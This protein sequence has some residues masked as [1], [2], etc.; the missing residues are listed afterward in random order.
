MKK[1][2]INYF[3]KLLSTSFLL[4]NLSVHSFSQKG[5]WILT[6]HQQDGNTLVVDSF[7][8]S[9]N[10]TIA[11]TKSVLDYK[12]SLNLQ[13]KEDFY[14][15][16]ATITSSKAVMPAYLSISKK[17]NNGEVPYNFDGIVRQ[18]NIYRQSPHEPNDY[19]FKGLSK[20][21]IP[22]LAI[23]D[24]M[25][26][27]VA[28]S[29]SPVFYDNYTTQT[30]DLQKKVIA[31]SAGDNGNIFQDNSFKPKIDTAT[32]KQKGQFRIEPHYFDIKE[33]DTHPFEGIIGRFNHLDPTK[34]RRAVNL[35]VSKNWSNGKVTDLFGSSFFSTAYMNLR[36]NETGKS[37]YWVV[38][39]I[40]YANK[41]YTRDAFW[42]SMILP[43]SFAA[44]CYE[45]E[46]FNDKI[47]TGA[48]RPL[49]TIIWA[50]KTLQ[51]GGKVDTAR[52]RRI[53]DITES[54][55]KN[56]YY[57]GYVKGTAGG[58]WQGWADNLAFEKEDA[59]SNNQGLFVVALM[60]AEQM[61]IHPKTPISL[62]L[63][64]YQHLFNAKINSFPISKQKDTVLSVDALM[65][66]LLSQVILG[67]TLVS[68]QDALAHYE[69]MKA[70]AMC[71]N[72][73]KDFC[74]ADGSYL[75]LEQYR[76]KSFESAI[77]KVID[78]EYQMGGSWYLYDM[79]MLMDAHIH[80]AKDAEDLMIWRTKLEFAKGNTTHEFINTVSGKPFKPNMGWNAGVY[81]IWFELMKQGKATNRFFKAID[82][83]LVK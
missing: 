18:S 30:F 37:K 35:I 74:N 62:A 54:H 31:I 14:T 65:G 69:T 60:C 64:N 70:K 45:N 3:I 59:I 5:K 57:S 39:A 1:C 16:S 68:K 17:Y 47:F 51:K 26:F 23:Y 4:L 22:M 61:G 20:Q 43:D 41:Q 40:E 9:D 33:K 77:E 34:L 24:K 48:E 71:V 81:G 82:D 72:G 55:A 13:P 79:L 25:G 38:P 12:V 80:G 32:I 10:K 27:E 6:I 67:K 73:F 11:F 28:I 50:Y 66:D 8:V 63:S 44:Y 2:V 83:Y 58:G 36:V 29:N 49:F 42:I 7:S 19:H 15:F 76:C 75:M 46:A 56:G 78:G 52:V 53:L 21:P